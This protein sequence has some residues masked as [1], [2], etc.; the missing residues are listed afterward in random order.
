[1]KV[2][3]PN[4]LAPVITTQP[5]SK[6]V[7][8]GSPVSFMVIA[9]G[10]TLSYQ[11]TRNGT[12]IVGATGAS[13]TLAT[14]TLADSGAQFR[15]RVTNSYGSKL[16]NIAVLTVTT[17][18]PPVAQIVTPAVGTT[19][20]GG[21]VLNY[22]GSAV[23]PENGDLPA[24]AFTWQIDFHHDTHLHPFLPATTGSKSGSVTIPDRGETSAN[25]FYRVILTTIDSGGLVSTTFRDV[26]PRISHM[27]FA[28]NPV[29]LQSSLDGTPLVAP[30][31]ITGVV[32]IKRTI[33][34]PSPQLS[35]ISTKC[36][37]VFQSWS[38]SLAVSHEI[39]GGR[40]RL[41]RFSGLFKC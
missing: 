7:S 31:T 39:S 28:T 13:Y 15:V 16:S 14:T 2:S 10:P 35:P 19:Y 41:D 29:G 11:W 6:T 34:A 24:S 17:N 5:D 33:A 36:C 40:A 25:V 18:K 30:Q 38:D 20:F 3:Y 12:N 27:T 21:M 32:G 9:S 26:F 23:D 37:F 8:V 4:S 22:S 1:M